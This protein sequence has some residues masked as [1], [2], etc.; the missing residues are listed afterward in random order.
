MI[1]SD[2]FS[3]LKQ[4]KALKNAGVWSN[5]AALANAL[6]GL[7]GGVLAILY[8]FGVVHVQIDQETVQAI[9]LGV[10]SLY[11]AANTIMHAAANKDAGL[12]TKQPEPMQEPTIPPDQLPS[13]DKANAKSEP[14]KAIKVDKPGDTYFG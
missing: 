1:I 7:L 13:W 6:A 3:A 9:A 5:R 14:D 10:A 11:A 8:S 4:G 12:P 2:F